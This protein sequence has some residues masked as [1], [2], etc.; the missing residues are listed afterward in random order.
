M[1]DNGNEITFQK[2]IIEPVIANTDYPAVTAT[3]TTASVY[4]KE[5]TQKSGFYRFL[6]GDRYRSV[7]GTKVTVP[8]V[9]SSR[10]HGGLNPLISGGGNQSLPL[11][12]QASRPEQHTSE[13]R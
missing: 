3:E 1:L 12:W 10:L 6:F 5:A 4:P 9:G 8:V 7:L 2:T 11:R 13:P